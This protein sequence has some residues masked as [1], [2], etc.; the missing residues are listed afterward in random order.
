MYRTVFLWLLLALTFG[1]VQTK[2][3]IYLDIGR[4]LYKKG[5][6]R[7]ALFYLVRSVREDYQNDKAVRRVLRI[8]PRAIGEA[9]EQ[10]QKYRRAGRYRTA[11]GEYDRAVLMAAM[12]AEVTEENPPTK[13]VRDRGKLVKLIVRDFYQKGRDFEKRDE[14]KEAA[15]TF[16]RCMAY[17]PEFKD[18]VKRYRH[19][20]VLATERL[21]VFPFLQTYNFYA[22]ISPSEGME[23]LVEKVLIERDPEFLQIVPHHEVANTVNSSVDNPKNLFDSKT[24]AALGKKLKVDI[25]VLGKVV[26]TGK[27]TGWRTKTNTRNHTEPIYREVKDDKGNKYMRRVGERFTSVTV[28]I[29]S[30]RTSVKI[31]VELHFV[32]VAT[33][34][35]VHTDSF[36]SQAQDG[37]KY[38]HYSGDEDLLTWEEEYLAS[39]SPREPLSLLALGIRC[40]AILGPQI[41]KM[42]DRHFK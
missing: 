19:Q 31:E 34:K 41:A 5:N 32:E 37:W 38:A 14:H 30:R 33:G 21:A 36:Y 17:A 16:R 28:Q 7:A 23:E 15:R 18:V 24:M 9:I 8:A 26:L 10:A 20:R 13:L 25:L 3:E 40:T 39:R 4:D 2:S 1:C 6:N 29:Y 12:A 27:D 35:V 22:K 42:I 11:L